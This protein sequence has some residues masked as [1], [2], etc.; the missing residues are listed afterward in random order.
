[1]QLCVYLYFMYNACIC[2][3]MWIYGY[4]GV[5]VCTRAYGCVCMYVG[6]MYACVYVYSAYGLWVVCMCVYVLQHT[7]IHT[8]THMNMHWNTECSLL[9]LLPCPGFLRWTGRKPGSGRRE[10]PQP[11]PA[12]CCSAD[13]PASVPLAAGCWQCCRVCIAANYSTKS[14]DLVLVS[15]GHS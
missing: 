13:I 11:C 12:L 9:C 7:R 14:S 15:R 1:M 2:M 3:Y 10:L 8:H 4:T 6:W 5:C